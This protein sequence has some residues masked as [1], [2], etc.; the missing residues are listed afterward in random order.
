MLLMFSYCTKAKNSITIK[1]TDTGGMGGFT[2]ASCDMSLTVGKT[3]VS[4]NGEWKYKLAVTTTQYD[5]KETGPNTFPSL[6]YNAM[7]APLVKYPIKGTIWYQGEENT[8][9]PQN[10]DTLF[11]TLIENWRSKWNN[12]FPFIWVQLANYMAPDSLP[13]ESNY[14]LIRNCQ[15]QALK[16][17][18][19]GEAVAIDLGEA[20]DI[21]PKNKQEVGYR[22]AL[23]ALKIAYNRELTCSGPVFKSAT[24][25]SDKI[26]I[27]F[28]NIAGGLVAKKDK[29]GFVRGFA[30]AGED[31]KFRWAQAYIS[32]DQVIVFNNDIKNPIVVKYAWGNNPDDANLYNSAGLPASPFK[33]KL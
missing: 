31:M 11:V 12:Q 17:P 28:G 21:H 13:S 4:L 3:L 2:G 30:I 10:Y 27:T 8:N 33:I 25:Q 22:L 20:N 5:L 32:G 1:T 7:V 9:Y 23:N 15:H 16:V 26:I 29:Y 24:T 18:N 6:L 19:T 14:A